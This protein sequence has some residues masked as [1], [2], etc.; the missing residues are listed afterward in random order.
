MEGNVIV[1]CVIRV[2]AALAPFKVSEP[3]PVE[4]GTHVVEAEQIGPLW[5]K[6]A[7]AFGCYLCRHLS[8]AVLRSPSQQE[9]PTSP[10]PTDV[11]L[12]GHFTS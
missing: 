1:T 5:L 10:G 9:T 3:Q 12:Q 11:E 2:D 8:P 4:P 7:L 6:D